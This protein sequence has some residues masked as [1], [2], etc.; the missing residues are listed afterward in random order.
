MEMKQLDRNSGVLLHIT[1]LPNNLRLGCFSCECNYFIDWLADGGF[2]TWQILPLVDCGY[3]LSPY[4]AVSSFAINPYLIDLT[5]FIKEEELSSLGLNKCNTLQQQTEIIDKALDII[6]EKFGKSTDISKFEKKHAYW[7]EDY[8]CYK[9]LKKNY[10]NSSWINFPTG[11]RDRIKSD[12]TSFKTKHADEIQKEKFIQFVAHSQWNAIKEYAHSKGV[13]IFGDIPFYVCLDSADVWANPKN[14][15][16][17]INGKGDVAGVPP[18]NFNAEGQLWGNPIYN[19]TAMSNDKYKYFINRFAHT[20]D[21]V[22]YIR[23]D[24]FV[25]FDKYYSI[26]KNST[27]AKNGRWIKG[28]GE[29]LLKVIDSKV[30]N[31]IIAEDLGN[32]TSSVNSLR[33]KFNIP[34]LKL[35]QF[36]FDGDGDNIYQPHHWGSDSV[37]YIGTHDNNTYL[38]MLESINWEQLNRI[39]KYLRIPLEWGND[40]VIDQ[41]IITM[42]RSNAQLII[43]TMQDILKLNGNARL[44]IPGTIENNW[45]WQLDNMPPHDLC[46][47]YKDLACTYGRNN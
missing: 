47:W 35:I 2:H 6:Y 40:A 28:G 39:K 22:D 1:S 34:G 43:L 33:K 15:K 36:A 9:V 20:G 23:I 18:D 38:G 7:L 30:A 44:N 42:Y 16:I 13:K 21:I 41:T 32:V 37:G 24:H 19:Y 25:A 17:D 3:G 10:N 5:E 12:I 29:N 45:L 46:W 14:W 31:P 27:S 8:A 11:L 4:N 26:P